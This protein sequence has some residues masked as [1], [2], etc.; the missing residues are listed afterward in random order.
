[1]SA[2]AIVTGALHK[3][4]EIRTSKNQ[5][6]FAVFTLRENVNGATRWWQAIAFSESAIETLREMQVG[7][8]IAVAGEITAKI[9][10]PASTESRINWRIT[11]DCVLN[12]RRPPKVEGGNSRKPK[13]EASGRD[14]DKSSSAGGR[15]IASKSWPSPAALQTG[16]A[17]PLDDSIPFCPE[18]R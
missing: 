3:A 5:N 13:K 16:G 6:Q 18:W 9:Y 1:M 14:R 12:A 2:R 15:A 8:P 17:A 7:E 11:C 10:A 4:A